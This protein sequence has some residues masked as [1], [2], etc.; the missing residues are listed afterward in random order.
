[1][2]KAKKKQSLM[3]SLIL[4]IVFFL[5]SCEFNSPD[6][7][8]LSFKILK[9]ETQNSSIEERLSVFLLYKDENGRNDYS[10]ITIVHAESNL[11]WVLNRENSSFFSSSNLGA[12][13]AGKVLWA[14]SN[15]ISHPLG[16]IP[17]GEYSIIA[18]DL[19]GNRSIKKISVKD[20]EDLS[21]LPFSFKIENK[22]WKIEPDQL[23]EFKKFSLIL[24]GADKQPLFVQVLPQDSQY[25]D[26]IDSLL[27]KYP[28]TRYIQC[29]AKTSKGDIAY[30]TKYHSLY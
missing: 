30:L 18:E 1:M 15:K 6:I 4:F 20:F 27:E 17:L 24:L 10:S 22:R 19:S 14:G 23:S 2:K 29:I 21:S 7:P 9:I 28:D 5:C 3:K 25:E 16:K 11:T 12:S 13:D 26:S 8:V